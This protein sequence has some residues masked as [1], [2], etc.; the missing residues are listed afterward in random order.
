MGFWGRRE[1]S[2]REIASV[3]DFGDGQQV[4]VLFVVPGSE[5]RALL[6]NTVRPPTETQGPGGNGTKGENGQE[7]PQF[8]IESLPVEALEGLLKRQSGQ[9]L[10]LHQE[11]GTGS[12]EPQRSAEEE[13]AGVSANGDYSQ[14]GDSLSPREMEI[15]AL[16]AKGAGNNKISETLFISLNTVKSHMKKIMRKLK[17]KDRNQTALVARIILGDI[18]SGGSGPE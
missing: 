15:L 1:R 6:G 3:I 14:A 2:R 13:T 8:V 12:P 18:S 4:M 10:V 17:T 11:N 5:L 7:A 16:I 9:V